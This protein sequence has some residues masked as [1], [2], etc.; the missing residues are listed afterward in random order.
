V[1]ASNITPDKEHGIGAWTDDQII[2]AITR[3]VSAD[4]RRLAPP[5]SNRAGIY[6]HITEGDLRDLIAYLRS[7]PPQ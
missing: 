6:S 3:G 5:M 1:V 4:G 7:L 2:G